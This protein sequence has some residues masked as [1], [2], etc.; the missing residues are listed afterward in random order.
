MPSLG[1]SQWCTEGGYAKLNIWKIQGQNDVDFSKHRYNLVILLFLASL[2]LDR[3]IKNK[4]T[5]KTEL[6]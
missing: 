1:S 4:K 2:N 5:D 3:S 6:Y